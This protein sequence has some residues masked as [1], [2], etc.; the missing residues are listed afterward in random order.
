MWQDLIAQAMGGYVEI[1]KA[2]AVAGMNASTGQQAA[3]Q[4]PTMMQDAQAK[5]ESMTTGVK[6]NPWIV[7][8][9]VGAAALIAYVVLK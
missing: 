6:A 1:E 4:S 7:P 5:A 2:K 8:L 9:A 3:I